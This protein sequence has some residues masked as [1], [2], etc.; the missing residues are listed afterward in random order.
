M[1]LR[2]P[3]LFASLLL[4][5]VSAYPQRT[6]GG[7]GGNTGATR[8]TTP[9]IPSAPANRGVRIEIQL[10][11]EGSRPLN[12][13]QAL[14]EVGTLSGGPQRTYADPDGRVNFNVRSG[15]TYQITVSGADIET[16]SS[17]FELMGDEMVH[18]EFIA[19][20]FKK[21]AANRPGGVISAATLNIP[22]KARAE[23][24]KGNAEMNDRKWES[25]KK[26]FEKAIKEYPKYDG[27]Y[28][29]LGVVEMQ[30]KNTGGA[31]QDFAKA[32]EL[33]DKN[34]DASCNLAQTKFTDND[35]PAAIELLKKTL[36]SDPQNLKA[37]ALLSFAQFRM[38]QFDAALASAQKVHQSDIDKYPFAHFIAAR[39]L[40]MKGDQ[41]GAESQYQ[42]YLKE[43]PEGEQ[44]S[45]AK[46]G[47]VRVQ[48]KK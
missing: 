36:A 7:G 14:I 2:R 45:L 11:D 40:E 32:L 26:H 35:F 8:P 19:I 16:A 6:P 44:A 17:S 15:G 29:N 13:V 31:K 38:S 18:R 22:E 9:N 33:N 43:A 24:E 34:P 21:N 39:V 47:L 48:A 5:C 12:N 30:L 28:N 42:A 4:V 20:K 3:L 37:T 1:R 25:A 27:A 10:T 41:A 23:F 46:E